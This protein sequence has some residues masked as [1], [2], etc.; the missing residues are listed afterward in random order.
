MKI[1]RTTWFRIAAVAF[2][3]IL[4]GLMMIIGRGHTIYLDDKTMEKNG[5]TY[6]AVYRIDVSVAGSSQEAQTLYERERVL[7]KNMGQKATLNLKVMQVKGG[8]K[9]PVDYTI[10]IPYSMD[11][12][13]INLPALLAGEGPDVYMSEFVTIPDVADKSAEVVV[14]D[15][16]AV[17]DI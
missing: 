5:K 16:F 15:E 13:I 10:S 7:V 17:T 2:I 9:V 3:L 1:S 8:D 6:Q 12:V 11:G 14:T 4:A